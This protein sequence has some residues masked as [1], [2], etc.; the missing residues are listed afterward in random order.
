MNVTKVITQ[1]KYQDHI[2]STFAYKVVC[3]DDRSTKLIAIYRGQNA[4]YEFIKAI[5]KEYEYSK[6]RMNI[7][8][9]KNWIMSEKEEHLFQQS[10]SWGFVKNLLIMMKKKLEVIVT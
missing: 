8:F 6:K 2:P 5:L 4:A 1:K 9:N 3:V 7:H 10:N